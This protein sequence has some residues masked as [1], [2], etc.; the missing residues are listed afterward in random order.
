MLEVGDRTSPVAPPDDKPP[1]EHG[2]PSVLGRIAGRWRGWSFTRR[3]FAVVGAALGLWALLLAVDLY[4]IQTELKTGRDELTS[5]TAK[6]VDEAGGIGPLAEQAEGHLREAKRLAHSSFGLAP[7][8]MVPGLRSQVHGLRQVVD[9]TAGLG[10]VARREADGLQSELHKGASADRRLVL[11]DRLVGA[12]DRIRS[13]V[14]R[15]RVGVRGFL[16]PPLSSARDQLVHELAK[17][18]HKLNQSRE[19]LAAMRKFIATDHNVLVLGSNN[20]EM[21]GGNG[22]PLSAGIA[23]IHNGQIDVGDFVPTSDL[24]NPIGPV[25]NLPPDLTKTYGWNTGGFAV[26]QEWRETDVSPNFVE[27]API[28]ARMALRQGM[29]K[30]DGVVMVDALALRALIQA[31][32]PVV[33]A[34]TRYDA[35]NVIQQVLNENYKIYGRLTANT[36]NARLD[37]QSQLAKLVFK[38]FNTRPVSA[39]KL[40]ASLLD[41]APGRHILAWSADPAIQAT[42]ERMG[43]A[44]AMRPDSMLVSVENIS[45]NKLDYYIIPYVGLDVRRDERGDWLVTAAVAIYNPP[46]AGTSQ[47]IEGVGTPD[48]KPFD[49]RV[50]LDLHLPGDAYS[51]SMLRPKKAKEVWLRRVLTGADPLPNNEMLQPGFTVIGLDPP[52]KVVGTRYTIPYKTSRTV[53]VQFHLPRI[54]DHIVVLPSGRMVPQVWSLGPQTW[55]DSAQ[56]TV[57]LATP[58]GPNH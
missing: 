46:R 40:A 7:L 5:L 32:G 28:Y 57:P 35:S 30:V 25:G 31:T 56:F 16:L 36:R 19:S 45:G 29:G 21:R 26:G 13:D 34:G 38:E 3:A 47:Q 43:I 14:A 58:V 4:R 52:N 23:H 1:S 53:V 22:M 41:V 17:I 9:V 37:L 6:R 8:S 18:R 12:V 11:I 2:T 24:W 50:Y 48:V 20:A 54:D 49:H 55:F 10:A 44:G 51:V 27:T 15:T 42:W 39:T 33:L